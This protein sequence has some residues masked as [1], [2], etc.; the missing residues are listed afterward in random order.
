MKPTKRYNRMWDNAVNSSTSEHVY[1]E[2]LWTKQFGSSWFTTTTFSSA[3]PRTLAAATSRLAQT[4]SASAITRSSRTP[5]A[6]I[7][8][9]LA[10]SSSVRD[11]RQLLRVL[12]FQVARLVSW[13]LRVRLHLRVSQLILRTSAQVCPHSSSV[14]QQVRTSS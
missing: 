14:L 4:T 11:S 1:T 3:Q 9:T 13:V 8:S 10:I 2:V 6:T 5:P 7:S 12:L